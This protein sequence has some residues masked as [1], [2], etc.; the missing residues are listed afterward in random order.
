MTKVLGIVPAR[1]GSKGIPQKNLALLNGHPLIAYTCMAARGS[2]RLDRT[3]VSTDD[4]G[5]A[6]VAGAHGVEAPFVRPAAISG[7]DVPMIDVVR[8]ALEALDNEGYRADAVAVLQ[9]T[10]PLRRAEHIDAAV[11]RFVASGAD[12]VVTVV[13]VPH[14]FSPASVLKLE[15]D[16]LTPYEIGPQILRRQDKPVLF[17]RNGPAVLV[18]RR[19]VIESGSLYGEHVEGVEMTFGESIDVDTRDDLALAEFWMAR[20]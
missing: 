9:P 20:G 19:G 8:H 18:V 15:A 13:R 14:Q 17:A 12:T 11:D 5:I 6:Q 10:S 2:A 7:D 4:R 16:Q 3:I 1:G